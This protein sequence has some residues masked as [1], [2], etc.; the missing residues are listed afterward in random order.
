M[1]NSWKEGRRRSYISGDLERGGVGR[2]TGAKGVRMADVETVPK[3]GWISNEGVER[4]VSASVLRSMGAE[5]T[6]PVTMASE[7]GLSSGNAVV[8]RP[9]PTLATLWEREGER[10][11]SARNGRC[12]SA[13]R[14]LSMSI[15]RTGGKMAPG[16][17]REQRRAKRQ[18]DKPHATEDKSRL[19]L[20]VF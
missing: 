11:S 5:G 4:G 20:D 19:A 6:T 10:S 3:L 2:A 15:V 8:R 13:L 7:Q 14:W 18:A 16:R 17:V 9:V 1:P 12:T